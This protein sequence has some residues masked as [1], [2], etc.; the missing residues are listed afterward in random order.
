MS[1]KCFPSN[2]SK[3]SFQL[4]QQLYTFLLSVSK[5]VGRVSYQRSLELASLFKDLCRRFKSTT[6]L[7]LLVMLMIMIIIMMKV[8]MMTMMMR[9]MRM[10]VLRSHTILSTPDFLPQIGRWS[11]NGQALVR[12]GT[13]WYGLV[14][15]GTGPT[16]VAPLVMELP[17]ASPSFQI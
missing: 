10:T 1:T 16:M 13:V 4:R 12:F 17:T 6:D 11:N 15:F 3:P 7:P 9:M 8:G 14:Q 5:P 2:A